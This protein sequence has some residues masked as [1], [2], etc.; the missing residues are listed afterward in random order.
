MKLGVD[1]LKPGG[2]SEATRDAAVV[3]FARVATAS[4]MTKQR[5]AMNKPFNAPQFLNSLSQ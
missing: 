3:S 4:A 1:T 2:G 5:V